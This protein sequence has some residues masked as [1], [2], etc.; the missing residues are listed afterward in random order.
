SFL[1]SKRRAVPATGL[2]KAE[3]AAHCRVQQRAA[4][5][6][7][8][9]DEALLPAKQRCANAL[10]GDRKFIVVEGLYVNC[11]DICPLGELVKLKYKY[12]VRLLGTLGATGRGICEEAGV[13]VQDVDL[14]AAGIENALATQG[15]FVVGTNASA[16]L[17]T[18]SQPA[19]HQC[20]RR[21]PRS[22]HHGGRKC[23]G[24]RTARLKSVSDRLHQRLLAE[25]DNLWSV[26]GAPMSPIK[27]LRLHRCTGENSLPALEAA[28]AAAADAG[29]LLTVA[30]YVAQDLGQPAQPSI[31]LSVNCNHSD[32]E[33]GS[34]LDFLKSYAT[35]ER[36]HFRAQA[37]RPPPLLPPPPFARLN[38]LESLRPD[39]ASAAAGSILITPSSSPSSRPSADSESSSRLCCTVHRLQLPQQATKP[40]RSR[41]GAPPAPPQRWSMQLP[42]RTRQ[43]LSKRPADEGPEASASGLASDAR[44]TEPRRDDLRELARLP[45]PTLPPP[46]SPKMDLRPVRKASV[47]PHRRL[48]R[49]ALATRAAVRVGIVYGGLGRLHQG[50]VAGLPVPP[51]WA[52]IVRSVQH[53]GQDGIAGGAVQQERLK[54]V[55]KSPTVHL[56]AELAEQQ[57]ALGEAAVQRAEICAELLD[58]GD[59]ADEAMGAAPADSGC[60]I[61]N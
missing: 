44:D 16:A 37:P 18:V 51:G 53:D 9:A 29:L 15:G 34:L 5:L 35:A 52:A 58:G 41:D 3:E 45:P 36:R 25:L 57:F 26:E 7:D 4:G 32:S 42:R 8:P 14:I 38:R 10:Q 59:G 6:A 2:S 47:T 27:H 20:W 50:G 60:N 31:R 24:E 49:R 55:A 61:V 33:I 30:R 21:P 23:V 40:K 1:P 19:C 56:G 46:P 13:S 54:L 48:T 12:K 39:T 11:G 28:C 22:A 43:Q 17:A